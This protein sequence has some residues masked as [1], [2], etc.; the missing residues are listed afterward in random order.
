MFIS[1]VSKIVIKRA[2]NTELSAQSRVEEKHKVDNWRLEK[3]I[4]YGVNLSVTDKLVKNYS[5]ITPLLTGLDRIRL[6]QSSVSN[7]NPEKKH[8]ISAIFLFFT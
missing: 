8:D 6:Y 2:Q 1:S 7:M 3:C 4:A 5:N